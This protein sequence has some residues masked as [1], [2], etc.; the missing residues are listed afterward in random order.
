[1]I[2]ICRACSHT[3]CRHHIDLSRLTRSRSFDCSK[4]TCGLSV[5]FSQAHRSI[6]YDGRGVAGDVISSAVFSAFPGLVSLRL[7]LF[8]HPIREAER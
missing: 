7:S 8:A 3:A 2:S 5:P 6:G 4:S 1:M